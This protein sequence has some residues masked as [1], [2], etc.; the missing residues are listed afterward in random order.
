MCADAETLLQKLKEKNDQCRLG[1][2]SKWIE[3]CDSIRNI[4]M[5]IDQQYPNQIVES[6]SQYLPEDAV[7]TTDVGQNQVWIA[8]SLK[9]KTNQR[10]LFSG[11]HGAMG[12]SLPAA[13]G[14]WYG[15]KRSIISFNGDGG[16]QMNLQELQVI[17]RENLSIKVVVF[18]NQSLGMIRHFQEMYF[19]KNYF[20]TING[21][22][23][24]A[25]DFSALAKAYGLQYAH[26]KNPNDFSESLFCGKEAA[27]IEVCLPERTYVYPKLEYGKPNNDQ[28]PLLKRELFDQLMSL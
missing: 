19:E 9:L 26:I 18:N 23:Y 17:R 16:L 7:I 25:P 2:W 3:V 8:Q 15:S 14:C 24:S 4:L 27:L 11:G 5:N 6:I 20:Q 28:E 10:L 22:G 21:Q 13:I 1:D 12:Y